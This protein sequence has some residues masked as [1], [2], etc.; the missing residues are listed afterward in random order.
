M[1]VVLTIILFLLVNK[2]LAGLLVHPEKV[3][4]ENFPQSKIE[5][6][7][8]LIT[9]E[10]AKQI[11]KLSNIKLKS[12]IF[13]IYIAKKNNKVVGYGILHMH[14]VRTKNEAVLI[15]FT[16]DCK[17]VDVEIIAFYEPP[18]YIPDKKWLNLFKNKTVKDSIR[19]KSDIPNI[20][21]ATLS[22]QAV[23]RAVKQATA[24]CEVVLKK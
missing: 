9:T 6:K 21:G 3:M 13:K 5:K 2:V 7:N 17:V 14:R 22:A 23:A 4:K 16:P 24:I 18:E 11:E 10:K 20:T 8:I 19:L 1:K 12:K 15:S